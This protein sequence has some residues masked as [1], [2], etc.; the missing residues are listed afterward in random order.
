VCSDENDPPGEPWEVRREID[1]RARPASFV[2]WFSWSVSDFDIFLMDKS[3]TNATWLLL[4]SFDD[5]VQNP[6]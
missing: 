4:R 1:G 3:S 5:C 2:P 6:F